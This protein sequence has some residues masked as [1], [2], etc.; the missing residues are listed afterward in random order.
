MGLKNF[1][2]KI[3]GADKII[4]KVLDTGK[5]V[6]KTVSN[7]EQASRRHQLD[8][9]SDS[10]LSKFVRPFIAIWVSV[11]FVLLHILALFGIKAEPSDFSMIHSILMLVI[12]FYFPARTI[13]KIIKRRF[14]NTKK[15]PE[16]NQ[17]K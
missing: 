9:S 10:R 1:L 5:D 8:M 2:G 6:L 17:D 12:S 16:K 15:D 11:M 13:E 14:P 3:T 7:K 4:G